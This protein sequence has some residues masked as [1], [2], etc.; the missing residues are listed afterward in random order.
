MPAENLIDGQSS[1]SSSPPAFNTSFVVLGGP[2]HTH[3]RRMVRIEPYSLGSRIAN[4][5]TTGIPR[6]VPRSFS[7]VAWLPG[8]TEARASP[9]AAD[10][11]LKARAVVGK[12]LWHTRIETRV[13]HIPGCKGLE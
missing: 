11:R 12:P 4:I 3:T 8:S 1:A 10:A 2:T 13:H 7:S 5:G 6:L 9:S